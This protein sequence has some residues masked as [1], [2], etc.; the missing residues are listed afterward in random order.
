MGVLGSDG[1]DESASARQKRGGN[2]E[3]E[4]RHAD[5]RQQPGICTANPGESMKRL[6][7]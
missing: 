2:E 3:G 7:R 4:P 1:E 6:R 5:K